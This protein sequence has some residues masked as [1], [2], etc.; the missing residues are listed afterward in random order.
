MRFW[1]IENKKP[2]KTHMGKIETV[3]KKIGKAQEFYTIYKIYEQKLAQNGLIDYS[4]MI[5]LVLNK[6]ETDE[7]FLKEVTKNYHYVLVD[8]YQDTS[9]VQNE[10]IFN[11]LKGANS[12]N[13]FVVGDD[14]QIIYSFQGARSRNLSDFLEKYPNTNVICLIE[15]RRST[16]TIL[17]F[18]NALIEQDRF[19]LTNNKN[20]KIE[21]KLIAKNQ[22]IIEKDC[23]IK[24]NIYSEY[25]QENN[26]IIE[27]IEELIKCGNKLSEIAILSRKHDQLENFAR[28]LKQKNIP[29]ALSK[30]KNAFEI[31]AL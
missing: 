14:D 21:K 28:L 30:Q 26:E 12:D 27:E 9:K 3:E 19:R 20:F 7:D 29:Y 10:I 22:K 5:N 25:I 11:I 31:S 6:M 1:G 13:I 16:Q 8:E 4:D 15:N 2:T 17:D 18:S 24:F 23:P